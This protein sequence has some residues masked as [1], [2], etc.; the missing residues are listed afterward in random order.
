MFFKKP[1]R[2]IYTKIIFGVVNVN[3]AEYKFKFHVLDLFEL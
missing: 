3:G 2:P 1:L